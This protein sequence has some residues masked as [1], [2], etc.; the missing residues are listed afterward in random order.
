MLLP[1]ASLGCQRMQVLLRMAGARAVLGIYTSWVPGSAFSGGRGS[2]DFTPQVEPRH[3]VPALLV[4]ILTWPS[5]W[6]PH[7]PR[8][9]HHPSAPPSAA[10]SQATGVGSSV[11]CACCD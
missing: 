7:V 5:S 2:A 10:L 6:C 4:L 3:P 8:P 11:G 1:S 9:S